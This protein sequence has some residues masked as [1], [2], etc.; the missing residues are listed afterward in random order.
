MYNLNKD[1]LRASFQNENYTKLEQS[2][3][4]ND[5]HSAKIGSG[6]VSAG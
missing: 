6:S 2:N 1:P 3:K 5:S 4:H